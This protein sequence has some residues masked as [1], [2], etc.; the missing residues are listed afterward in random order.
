MKEFSIWAKHSKEEMQKINLTLEHPTLLFYN[1]RKV[2]KQMVKT[3]I[4][5]AKL[6]V[7]NFNNY[8]IYTHIIPVNFVQKKTN[9][10]IIFQV[11]EKNVHTAA[12]F[13]MYYVGWDVSFGIIDDDVSHL[14]R[15]DATYFH[16]KL[17]KSNWAFEYM[18]E[19]LF[20]TY[21]Q[22]LFQ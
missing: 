6:A 3:F 10:P 20:P 19:T 22:I 7:Q 12:N 16:P 15:Q 5:H 18:V 17:P 4:K 14:G 21:H 9:E 8:V 13:D 2:S 1:K 11:R